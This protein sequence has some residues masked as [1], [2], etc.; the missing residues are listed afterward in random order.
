MDPEPLFPDMYHPIKYHRTRDLSGKAKYRSRTERPTRYYLTDFGLSR[1][2]ATDDLSPQEYPIIGGDQSVPEFQ[3][4]K[5]FEPS[6]PFPTDVYYAG[7][8][9]RKHYLNVRITSL[10]AITSA[11]YM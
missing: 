9:I 2:Y 8:L 3:G 11:H 1:K 5:E 6:N 4:D 7:N 10:A